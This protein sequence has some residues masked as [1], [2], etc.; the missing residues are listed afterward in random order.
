MGKRKPISE[1]HPHLTTIGHLKRD[2][3]YLEKEQ[4]I[5]KAV[6]NIH[7]ALNLLGYVEKD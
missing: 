2:L 3:Y 6:H 5:S 4:D 1:L 7:D